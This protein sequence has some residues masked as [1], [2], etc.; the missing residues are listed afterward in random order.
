MNNIDKIKSKSPFIFN[1]TFSNDL[2]YEFS[3]ITNSGVI[4]GELGMMLNDYQGEWP[5]DI[6]LEDLNRNKELL[7]KFLN[8]DHWLI[9]LVPYEELDSDNISQMLEILGIV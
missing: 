2:G 5:F 3:A 1:V 8:Q 9:F 7:N 4:F 6:H